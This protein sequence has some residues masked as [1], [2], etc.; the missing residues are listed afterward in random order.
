M[1][2][3]TCW[4]NLKRKQKQKKPPK[5]VRLKRLKLE[6]RSQ[7]SHK[8]AARLQGGTKK[9]PCPFGWAT[10]TKNEFGS[11]PPFN[12]LENGQV[13]AIGTATHHKSTLFSS[14]VCPFEGLTAIPDQSL[15]RAG[16]RAGMYLVPSVLI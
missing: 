11:P 16:A 8:H 3:G 10:H 13:R 4:L 2:C 14:V 1:S 12:V 6:K 15:R 9:E 7:D 5:P